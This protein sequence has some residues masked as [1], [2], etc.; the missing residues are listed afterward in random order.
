V[1]SDPNYYGGDYQQ[2]S[3]TLTVEV[4]SGT[5]TL[6][7]VTRMKSVQVGTTP[8]TITEQV[9]VGTTTRTITEQG[10]TGTTMQAVT[11]QVQVGTTM[12]EIT[13]QGQIDT[14]T[15]EITEQVQ[16]GVSPRI[17]DVGLPVYDPVYEMRTRTVEEPVYGP[18]TR[19]VEV[20]KYESQTRMVEVPVY[21][22]VTRTVE[23]P[24]Y[25][26]QT[27]TVDVPVFETQPVTE[28]IEVPVMTTSSTTVTKERLVN[29]AGSAP[30]PA[31]YGSRWV[32]DAVSDPVGMNPAFGDQQHNVS[33]TELLCFSDVSG[34]NMVTLPP[35]TNGS[36]SRS[37]AL[38][39]YQAN[40]HAFVRFGDVT[41]VTGTVSRGP[42]G[43]ILNPPASSGVTPIMSDRT[44]GRFPRPTANVGAT[45]RNFTP[46]DVFT[47][48][49]AN[50]LLP[51]KFEHMLDGQSNTIL[52][53]EGMRLCNNGKTP[54]VAFL[55]VGHEGSEHGFGIEPTQHETVGGV[56]TPM[57]PIGGFGNT[58][59][60]QLRPGVKGCNKGR[61][62]ANHEDVLNVAMAD[63]SVRGISAQ[64]SRRELLDPD[65]AGR[66]VSDLTLLTGA[67]VHPGGLGG[68][69]NYSDGVWDMLMMPSDG[70]DGNV[71]ANTGEIGREK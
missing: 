2:Y 33:F 17:N 32:P 70:A 23:E 71:L 40:A 62:Q 36:V 59:M 43:R 41:V 25:G 54:R 8:Q 13:E 15:R 22:A 9:Q 50:G 46:W 48:G 67:G 57:T 65:V 30:I 49:T 68:R 3:E 63:G 58:L 27:R 16:V 20:P 69:T 26:P 29:V 42:G 45:V 28:T 61:L 37:W 5:T 11:E 4:P 10:Q 7:T 19:M 6:E 51:R 12:E 35:T 39:N 31:V 24:V 1:Q 55:S 66:T 64:V 38:T 47:T 56:A 52:F 34:N 44:G 60:F 18:V 14:T 21:G 53:G